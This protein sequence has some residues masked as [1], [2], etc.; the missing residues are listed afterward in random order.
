MNKSNNLPNEHIGEL[1]HSDS[2]NLHNDYLTKR[3][4][5]ILNLVAQGYTSKEISETLF[6]SFDTAETHRRN[7]IT[8]LKA[9][10][11]A[12]AVAIAMKSGI[13]K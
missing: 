6:I 2:L 3:E 12:N 10:N 5:E 4:I 8:K 7:I 1:N 11:I 9:K 13:L